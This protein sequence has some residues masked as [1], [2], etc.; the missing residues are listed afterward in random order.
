MRKVSPFW[1]GLVSSIPVILHWLVWKPGDGTEIRIGGDKILG[2][3]DRSLLSSELRS[4]L[5]Q[6]NIKFLAQVKIQP[7]CRSLPD[8]GWTVGIYN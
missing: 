3:G 5:R 4:L 2:L 8:N 7:G 6:Q 1:K